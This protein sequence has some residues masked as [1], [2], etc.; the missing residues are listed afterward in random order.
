MKENIIDQSKGKIIRKEFIGGFKKEDKGKKIKTQY[1]QLTEE[2]DFPSIVGSMSS[3]VNEDLTEDFENQNI[4]L[5]RVYEREQPEVIQ[6]LIDKGFAQEKLRGIHDKE[7]E[8]EV[9]IR[10]LSKLPT[11]EAAQEIAEAE[12][13]V[14]INE[15]AESRKE[16]KRRREANKLS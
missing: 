5:M 13:I 6:A 7:G 2:T 10:E 16:A 15:E 11:E 14:K 12:N 8:I 1:E 9:M 3:D 4:M